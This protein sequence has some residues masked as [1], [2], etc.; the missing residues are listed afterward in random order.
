MEG[1]GRPMAIVRDGIVRRRREDGAPGR[2]GTRAGAGRAAWVAG[3]GDCEG[4]KPAPVTGK[5]QPAPLSDKASDGRGREDGALGRSGITLRRRGAGAGG[6]DESCMRVRVAFRGVPLPGMEPRGDGGASPGLP[7]RDLEAEREKRRPL[8]PPPTDLRQVPATQGAE[9]AAVPD[10]LHHRHRGPSRFR[11]RTG[12]AATVVLP[13]Y[14]AVPRPPR[15]ADG[16]PW[17]AAA[18][19]GSEARGGAC[20]RSVPSRRPEGRAARWVWVRGPP[21]RRACSVPFRDV[22]RKG[23]GGASR[24]KPDAPARPERTWSERADSNRRPP[25]PQTGALPSCAT[26]RRA[27]I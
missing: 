19:L 26:L 14:M 16:R 13:P 12:A 1:D 10:G 22:A 4:E 24:V 8:R 23:G 20:S 25:V 2:A 7:C 11:P 9:G 27:R 18:R 15:R 17:Q 21:C 6:R 5:R 3:T